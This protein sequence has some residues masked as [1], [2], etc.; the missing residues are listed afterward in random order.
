MT[1]VAVSV[2]AMDA[3]ARTQATYE[4]PFPMLSDPDLAAH[5]A[6]RVVRTVDDAEAERLRR[7]GIE[8]EHW[9]GRGHHKI[10]VPAIFLIDRQG[11]VRFAH[12]AHDYKTR[13]RLEDVIARIG[14]IHAD[15]GAP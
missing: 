7:M 15:A 2:D 1:P 6:Y 8:L 4:V 3:V 11:T 12:A 5:E 13:P 9:S 10:A 14:A